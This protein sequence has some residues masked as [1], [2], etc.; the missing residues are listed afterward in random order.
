MSSNKALKQ[1]SD[2]NSNLGSKKPSIVNLVEYTKDKEKRKKERRAT[3]GN[4]AIAE[5]ITEEESQPLNHTSHNYDAP[6]EKQVLKGVAK[7]LVEFEQD[8]K[9]KDKELQEI[10][11]QQDPKV[12]L[13]RKISLFFDFELFK[14]FVY[15]NI[16]IGITIANFAEINFSILTPIILDE[17]NFPKLEI[18][19]FMSLLGM[20]DIV[21]RF[22]VPFIADK[23]GW[24]NRTFFLVGVCGMAS[25]RLGKL[26]Q[27]SAY[28]W[29]SDTNFHT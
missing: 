3:K 22:T 14:D 4:F 5:G 26:I 29:L 19:Q 16:M 8:Q 12:T 17:F 13:W 10:S 2:Q 18:A 24:S 20:T 25:A 9:K 11:Q 28:S 21:V 1:S 23:I 15:V 7:K 27:N 6:D